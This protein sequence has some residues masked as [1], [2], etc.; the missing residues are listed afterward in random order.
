MSKSRILVIGPSPYKSKG[1]MATVINDIINDEQL[2]MQFN[3]E[4]YESY[5]DGHCIKRMV[6]SIYSFLR[7]VL[8]KKNYDVYHIHVASRGS[9]FRKAL[10]VNVIK[11]WEKKIILHIHGAEFL[12]FYDELSYFSRLKLVETLKK[13]DLVLALS[14]LWKKEFDNIFLLDNCEVLEN[15]ID[16]NKYI[17]AVREKDSGQVLFIMLGRLGI[18]KGT[19]DLIE[20]FDI[21]SKKHRDIKLILAGDGELGKIRNLIHCKGLVS[22]VEVVGWASDNLKIDLLKKSAC[23]ILPSYD[24]GLP[25]AI[26]EGMASGKAIISTYV[27][28]IPELIDS[29][30]GILLNPGDILALADAVTY[31][32]ENPSLVWNI[33]KNNISKVNELYSLENMHKKLSEYYL[34][35]LEKL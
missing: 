14:S 6:F 29:N 2:N 5:I 9:A 20:A 34:Q 35:C 1:G 33:G 13:A 24:E 3:I 4:L 16:T 7:F 27:G 22:N 17:S 32:Y 12:K 19:Y 30:N 10:Y 31:Y 23:L 25:M 8:N 21:V 15:G 11:R 26:L 28:A 18:R